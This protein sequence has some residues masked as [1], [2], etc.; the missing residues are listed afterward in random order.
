MFFLSVGMIF[1]TGCVSPML[2]AVETQTAHY[3]D[4]AIKS[5]TEYVGGRPHGTHKQ[6]YPDGTLR[7]EAEYRMGA[8]Q[9]VRKIYR[10][11]GT[12]KTATHYEQNVIDGV[13]EMYYPTGELWIKNTYADGEL[14]KSETFDK[15][16]NL[17]DSEEYH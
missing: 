16:G 14:V 13:Q 6:Y 17:T 15:Q 3:E 2:P 9:G 8:L 5:V 10:E 1:L 7:V 11:D 4:G 12:A